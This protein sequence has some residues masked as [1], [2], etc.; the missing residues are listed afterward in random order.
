MSEIVGFILWHIRTHIPGYVY[1]CPPIMCVFATLFT[2]N[3]VHGVLGLMW[4]IFAPTS[5]ALLCEILNSYNEYIQ[6][7]GNKTEET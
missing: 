7:I 3:E 5:Y 2:N 4:L 6:L 1:F